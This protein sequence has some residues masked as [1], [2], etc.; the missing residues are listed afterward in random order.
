MK[1]V[2]IDYA[3][4]ATWQAVARMYN[5]EAKN[6]DST[7]AVGFTLLSIDP[8]TGTPSTALGPKMGMEATS[9]SRILKSMEKKGLILRKPNPD[10]GR[11]V[12]IYLTEMGL[13]KRNLSKSTVLQ[14]NEAIRQEVDQEKILNFFE[15]TETIN[16]LIADKK[17]F[18]KNISN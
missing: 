2:T 7:M 15:V 8:K 17:L 3:L 4:R 6:F 18:S 16:K 10:D 1:E 5:E 11:G 14:F 9:L 13:E 12:L